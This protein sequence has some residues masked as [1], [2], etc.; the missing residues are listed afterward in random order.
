MA[1]VLFKNIENQNNK[2][3]D[4]FKVDDLFKSSILSNGLNRLVPPSGLNIT[5]DELYNEIKNI[6]KLRFSFECPKNLSG[7]DWME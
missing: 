3:Q 4:D 2:E 7:F 5:P 6:A 1:D